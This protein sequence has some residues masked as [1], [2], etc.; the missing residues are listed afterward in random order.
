M[1]RLLLPVLLLW[2]NSAS[3][4]DVSIRVL[5]VYPSH[6]T[7]Q[8]TYLAEQLTYLKD[9]W[10][11]TGL[12]ASSGIGVELVNGGQPIVAALAGMPAT[13]VATPGWAAANPT[14]VQLRNSWQA[15][16]IVLLTTA[17][18]VCGAADQY[19]TNGQFFPDA[20]GMDLN[21][22]NTSYVAVVSTGCGP[23][24]AAHEFGHLL[25]GG[26]A[27][28]ANNPR[29][30]ADS[31]A[32][33]R[34]VFEPWPINLTYDWAT[35]VVSNGECPALGGDFCIHQSYYSRNAPEH[36]NGNQQNARTFNITAKSVAN[37]IT[38]PTPPTPILNPPINVH[39]FLIS[40]C[41]PPGWTRHQVHW[42]DDPQTNVQITAYEI[43]HSQPPGQ[44]VQFTGTISPFQQFSDIYVTGANSQIYVKA[45]SN[46]QCSALS[47]SSYLAQFTC[48][49]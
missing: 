44:P 17:T 18:D 24:T 9:T 47:A 31:R 22:R 41:D 46:A 11:N 20:Q 45:C 43:W 21:G 16:V 29:L 48:L 23:L 14:I 28:T 4:I 25:G 2:T 37:Y 39:G 6:A 33:M 10:N 7:G 34:L 35:A 26:H 49:N 38:P 13:V 27:A 42:S 8:V 5:G 32:Y 30:Y 3:A 1:R 12:H 15:D 19:F 40:N 36:G